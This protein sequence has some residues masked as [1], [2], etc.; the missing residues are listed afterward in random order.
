MGDVDLTKPKELHQTSEA[1]RERPM[2]VGRR[3]QAQHPLSNTVD[4]PAARAPGP[5][6]LARTELL[7]KSVRLRFEED[8]DAAIR[9]RSGGE[10]KLAGALRA[11]APLS[12]ALRATLGEA[13]SVLV[14]R[15][16]FGREL[17]A[18]GLRALAEAQ[19]HQVGALLRRALA[20]ED[21]GGPAALSASCFSRES[22]LGDRLAKIASSH[23]SHVAFGA[24]LA[25]VS[26][27]ESNGALLAEL[28]PKIKESHRIAMCTDLFVPLV[29]A[30]QVS[31][32]VV[33]AFALLRSAERH[34][35][36]WLLLAEIAVRAGDL[37]ALH[38][39]RARAQAGAA[40]ARAAWTLVAW[41]LDDADAVNCARPRP[42]AP[43]VRPTLELIA[44]LSDRPSAQRDMTFLFRMASAS[45]FPASGMLESY[46]RAL[47]LSD[48]T[49][50]RASLCLA[51]DHGR[52]DMRLA[53]AMVAEKGRRED[54][55][56]LAAAAYWDTAVALD[57][58]S[59]DELRGHTQAIA[60]GLLTSRF[61]VNRAWGAL[62]CAAHKA[63]AGVMPLVCESSVRWLQSG[64]LE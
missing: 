36:R 28:A 15:K 48:E 62:I 9:R 16:A 19:D 59:A 4:P 27:G 14:E 43:S 58:A 26:R 6:C 23:P 34:L 61:V 33:P 30:P 38:E 64:R 52:S 8:I 63:G 5:R 25:R 20:A 13:T 42:S 40:S 60:E 31:S 12:P 53:L 39:A 50:I 44:R 54:L 18:C 11:V 32:G 57:G 49:A 17:C 41:A 22:E 46:A 1:D 37:S 56:G 21:A 24:E 35:G 10:A 2:R 29:R 51:R 47:P 3:R 55:R 45:P 7:E